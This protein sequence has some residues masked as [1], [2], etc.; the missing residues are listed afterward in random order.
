MSRTR[1]AGICIV[2][3]L[4][5]SALA[6]GS[7]SA[8]LPELGRCVNVG[9]AGAYT[10]SNCIKTSPTHTGKFEWQPGPGATPQFTAQAATVL[11]E[12]VGKAKILCT[13]GEA[14][15]EW[16]GAKTATVGFELF[17]CEN[18]RNFKTCK[19]GTGEGTIKIEPLEGELGT[20]TGGEKP[21]VGLDL[22]AKSPQPNI[23][24]FSCGGPPGE[25][26]GVA[27]LYEIE[28]SVIARILSVN[29]MRT[30]T[31]VLYKQIA[32]KQ[33]PEMFEGSAKDTLT[34]NKPTESKAE[35]AG[36]SLKGEEHPPI[37][38]NTTESL[39]VKTIV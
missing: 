32:G 34:L 23:V 10:G 16:T 25:P 2:A 5:L 22:K 18:G 7:A 12:T 9:S 14:T 6:A 29:R 36:L 8:A 21:T 19:S 28:G 3:A 31:N 30:E 26:M 39:E 37:I 20:I 17:G 11:L 15:G 27:E 35:Q 24:S 38:F 13:F 1:I 33:V 4:A